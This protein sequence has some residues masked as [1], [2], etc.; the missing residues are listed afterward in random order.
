MIKTY[1]ELLSFS[2]EN[3]EALVQ[4]GTLAAKGYEELVKAYADYSGRN[5]D[6]ATAAVKTLAGAKSIHE[7]VQLQSELTR[8]SA[9]SFVS[10]S[11]KFAEIANT[12]ATSAMAPIQARFEAATTLYK[13]AA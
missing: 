2:K 4:S 7:L 6:K 3:I 5:L 10:E 12:V 13:T 1:E 11:R 9:D 8:E